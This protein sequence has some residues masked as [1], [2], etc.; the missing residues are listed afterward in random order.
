[1]FF[2]Y[3]SEG[4]VLEVIFEEDLHNADQ[5]AYELRKGI[6]LYFTAKE[7]KLVQLT[8][9][10]YRELAQMPVVDF[11]EWRKLSASAK[12]RLRPIVTSSPIANF[13]KL[14]PKTGAGHIIFPARAEAFSKAA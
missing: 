2:S 14:D 8:L 11:A 4:D 5:M 13:L 7:F 12:K 3:D 6:V 9:V 10:S 1:M